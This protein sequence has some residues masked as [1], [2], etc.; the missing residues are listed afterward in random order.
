MIIEY[1]PPYKLLVFNLHTRLL[2]VDNRS[3]NIQEDIINRII[4]LTKPNE[5]FIYYFK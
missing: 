2:R 4:I 5:K 1:K 3:M